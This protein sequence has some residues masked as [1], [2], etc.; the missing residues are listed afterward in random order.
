MLGY[1]LLNLNFWVKDHDLHLTRIDGSG[2]I[3][4]EDKLTLNKLTGLEYNTIFSV[5]DLI[6]A[7]AGVTILFVKV[8]NMVGI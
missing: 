6:I 8:S 4:W 1:I 2:Q 5:Y 7:S 3:G